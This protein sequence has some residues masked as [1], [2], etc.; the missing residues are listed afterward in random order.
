MAEVVRR[1]Y[2]R[3]LR[4]AAVSAAA[5]PE[6]HDDTHIDY[7]PEFSQEKLRDA[8]MRVAEEPET[9]GIPR[10]PDLIIVDGGKGQLSA[11]CRELQQLGLHEVPIIGLAKEF[12][13]IHRPGRA[14]PLILSRT[15][16]ARS[17]SSSASATKRTASPTATTSSS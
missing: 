5:R 9:P 7:A 6:A 4:D 8:V 17:C 2:A 16:A 15:T 3:V 13:E 11:A 12:E 14:E 10:L 1:R